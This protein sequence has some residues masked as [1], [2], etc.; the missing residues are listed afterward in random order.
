[1]KKITPGALVL[2]GVCILILAFLVSK[3]FF[4]PRVEGGSARK[5]AGEKYLA[6]NRVRPGVTEWSTGEQFEVL[7]KGEGVP[8]TDNDVIIGNWYRVNFDGQPIYDGTSMLVLRAVSDFSLA[9]FSDALKMIRVGGKVR[10]SIPWNR[11]TSGEFVSGNGPIYPDETAVWEMTVLKLGTQRERAEFYK[12]VDTETAN[13]LIFNVCGGDDPDLLTPG[14][15]S[16]AVRGVLNPAEFGVDPEKTVPI[17]L[18]SSVSRSGPGKGGRVRKRWEWVGPC[19]GFFV[20]PEIETCDPQKIGEYIYGSGTGGMDWSDSYEALSTLDK[21]FDGA[22]SGRE[23]DEVSIWVDG[24]TN[25][26]PDSGE[27]KKAS[28]LLDRI[29]VRPLRVSHT[30]FMCKGDGVVFKDGKRGSSWGWSTRGID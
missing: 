3:S 2:G 24:N 13:F 5:I 14:D 8:L 4:T 15:W 1:M 27:V 9:A 7:K 25:G 18:V 28:D 21:N 17:T 30:D 12:K 20:R 22:I 19:T 6:A 16:L 29:N 26:T 23:L 10:V 11:K